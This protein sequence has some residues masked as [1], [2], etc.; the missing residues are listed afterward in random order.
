VTEPPTRKRPSHSGGHDPLAFLA[1]AF[2]PENAK[3]EPPQHR[4]RADVHVDVGRSVPEWARQWPLCHHFVGVACR[5]IEHRLS[6]DGDGGR[7]A[8]VSPATV[9]LP[10]S[11]RAWWRPAPVVAGSSGNFGR[12]D[13]RLTFPMRGLV[14]G[15]GCVSRLRGGDWPDLGDVGCNRRRRIRTD[16]EEAPSFPRVPEREGLHVNANPMLRIARVDASRPTMQK[17]LEPAGVMTADRP[18]S[19]RGWR[20]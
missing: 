8:D 18:S 7:S 19:R 14:T 6:L 11:G 9:D 20:P 12:R 17:P 5:Q 2:P 4:R 15:R 16:R 10:T 13:G 1:Q 3:P